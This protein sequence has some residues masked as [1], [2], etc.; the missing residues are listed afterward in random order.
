[1]YAVFAAPAVMRHWNSAPPADLEEAGEWA[2]HLEN[3]Q[4]RLGYAEWR[5]AER[6]G[7]RLVGIAGLQPLDGGPDVELTYALV[8]SAWGAGYA[9]EAGAAA[10]EYGFSEAGLERIAGIARPDNAASLAVLR[11]LGLRPLGRA[12]HWGREWAK[13]QLTAA[14]WK[15]EQAAAQLPLVTDRL[16]LRRLEEADAESL[17]DVFGDAE[18]MRYVGPERR[19]L[20]GDEVRRLSRRRRRTGRS[21]GSARWPWSSGR[22]GASSGRPACRSWRPA[23]TWRSRLHALRA[24]AWGRGYATEADRAILR[25]GFAGLRLPRIVAVTDPENHTS[26]RVVEK[27]GMVS[28]GPRDCYGARLFEY[29]LSLGAWRDLAGPAPARG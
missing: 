26:Q 15:A 5:V 9:T 7:D 19:P 25:W 1:M 16:E 21:T 13:Y 23:R 20:A 4:R 6:A 28:L 27:L 10:L 12:E 8:P 18:V 22:A 29:G 11:K 2:A 17:L 14:A 3:M 24:P